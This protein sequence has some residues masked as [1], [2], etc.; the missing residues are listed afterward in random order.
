M[1]A[2]MRREEI[3]YSSRMLVKF[4]LGMLVSLRF[5]C[6]GYTLFSTLSSQ[7]MEAFQSERMRR[8]EIPFSLTPAK[9]VVYKFE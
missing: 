8:S 1:P 3:K 6:F 2:A 9:G 4:P 7:S 5:S